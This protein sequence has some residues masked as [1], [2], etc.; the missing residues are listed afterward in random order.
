MS[1]QSCSSARGVGRQEGIPC[2]PFPQRAESQKTLLR[3][4]KRRGAEWPQ[5][6]SR[7]THRFHWNHSQLPV[8]LL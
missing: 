8:A 5:P 3:D 6:H 7:E 2:L 4:L 1:L